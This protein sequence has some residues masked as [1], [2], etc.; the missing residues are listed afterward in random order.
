MIDEKE[1]EEVIRRFSEES[2]TPVGTVFRAKA[3]N[4]SIS[5]VISPI[6]GTRFLILKA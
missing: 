4:F 6:A 3:E 5:A 2:K 1:A